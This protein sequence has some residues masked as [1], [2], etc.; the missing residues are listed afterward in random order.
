MLDVTCLGPVRGPGAGGSHVMSLG[1]AFSYTK[2][3][4]SQARAI[5]SPKGNSGHLICPLGSLAGPDPRSGKR[6][7]AL[8]DMGSVDLNQI[9]PGGGFV[10]RSYHPTASMPGC[11]QLLPPAIFCGFGFAKNVRNLTTPLRPVGSDAL[12]LSCPA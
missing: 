11:L 12:R 2:A 7:G 9:A 3:L 10:E 8:C 1:L 6:G 4:R 5:L